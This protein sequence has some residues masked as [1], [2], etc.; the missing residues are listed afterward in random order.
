MPRVLP[1]V[2]AWYDTALFYYEVSGALLWSE[3]LSKTSLVLNRLVQG[4]TVIAETR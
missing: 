1:K 4:R 3:A 2:R